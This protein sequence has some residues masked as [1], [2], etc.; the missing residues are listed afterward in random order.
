MNI[1][2][3]AIMYIAYNLFWYLNYTFYS[4]NFKYSY[5]NLREK[6][7]GEGTHASLMN[8]NSYYIDIQTNNNS[9]SNESK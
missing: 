1:V 5:T 9:S 2:L 4:H 7:V 6:I 3:L 8:E